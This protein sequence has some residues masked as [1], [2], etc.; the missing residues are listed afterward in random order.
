MIQPS[1]VDYITS[2]IKAGV[3][4]DAIK[5]ALVGV[6]WQVADV[7]DSLVKAEADAKPVMATQVASVVAP[8]GVLCS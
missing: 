2:Q 8:V 3:S 4:H 6:G 1:L 5:A 7:E